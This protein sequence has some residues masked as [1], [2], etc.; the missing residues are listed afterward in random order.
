MHASAA[1]IYMVIHNAISFSHFQS[2]YVSHA[3]ERPDDWDPMNIDPLT[4]KEVPYMAVSITP[5]STEYAEAAHQLSTSLG[6]T[7]SLIRCMQMPYRGK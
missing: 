7:G 1:V 2:L 4:G 3:G 6:A 5:G